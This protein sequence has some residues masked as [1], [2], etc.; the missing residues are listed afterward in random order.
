MNTNIEA[1]K[2]RFALAVLAGAL[3]LASSTA[4]AGGFTRGE[5]DTDIL[6][7]E[8]NYAIRSGGA[9][10]SPRRTY[11][12]LN[13]RSSSDSAYSDTFWVPGVA[14]KAKLGS[15]PVTCALTYT[16]PFGVDATYGEQAQYAEAETATGQGLPLVNPTSKLSFSTDEYGATCAVRFDAGRGGLHLIGGLFYETFEY[17]EDT[18]FGSIHLEDDGGFGYRIGAAYDIPEYAMRFQLMYRSQVKH[19]AEG[20]FTPSEL[21][22][23]YGIIGNLPSVGGGTLPQSVKLSAQTGIAPGW[24]AYGSVT[25]TDWSALPYFRYDVENL[26]QSIKTFNYKDGYTIQVGVG[27]EFTQKLSGTVNLTWD[28]GVGSGADI[29]TDTWTVGL[30]SEYKTEI[31]TFGLGVSFSYLTE[32]SQSETKGATF[33]ATADDDW[34][35]AV[36]VSYSYSF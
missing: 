27:H 10:V 35:T 14:L 16:Q 19:D 8:G 23:S 17:D 28:Q 33:N 1:G 12:T 29:A 9:Y 5:A 21:A 22:A 26:A 11:S 30:G 20:T 6:F 32:G 3:S 13:G 25:W 15:S 36:G 18:W 34:A 2:A 31:G 4:L 7:M 24:L